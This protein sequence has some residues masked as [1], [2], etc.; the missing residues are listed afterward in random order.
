MSSKQQQND[1]PSFKEQLDHQA[2]LARDPNYGKE[3]PQPTLLEKVVDYVPAAGKILGIEKK[4]EE[5]AKTPKTV[6]P[7][8][9]ERPH[10]DVPIE[11]FLKDQHRSKRGANGQALE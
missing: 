4:E 7:G 10:H 6:V 11:E 9:P 3:E 1:P 2:R 5:T 8:P